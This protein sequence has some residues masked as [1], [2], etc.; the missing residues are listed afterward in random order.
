MYVRSSTSCQE[1]TRRC[2]IIINKNELAINEEIRDKEIR[3]IDADNNMLGIMSAKEAQKIANAK[4]LDL[5]KIAPHAVPPVCRI[6]DYG[7]Y[8]FNLAKKEKEARKNQKVI[9][10][11]E[12]RISPSI[13][14]HDFNVKVKNA[15]KFLQDGDK[16]KVNIR[17]RG[18]EMNYTSMGYEVLEKFAEKVK[19]V[20]VV[21]KKPKLEGKSMI[22]IINP[23]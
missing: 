17:F 16:V 2:I 8:M 18:R 12:I 14:E 3:V 21:E 6:M 5:V 23:K 10:V 13:E 4:N 19:D 15:M 11:K 9:N 1:L 20:G 22:M 7:K